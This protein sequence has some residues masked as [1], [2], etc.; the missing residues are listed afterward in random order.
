[1]TDLEKKLQEAA[2][3]YYTDGTS[4][5]TDEEFDALVDQLRIEQPDS[6]LFKVGWG[7]DVADDHTPGMKRKH[8][9]TTIGS[10]DKC[11]D[12]KEIGRDFVGPDLDISTKL[13]GLSCVLYYDHGLLKYALTRGDSFTGIDITDKVL[14]IQPKFAKTTDPF[15]GAIRGEIL[16]S[17]EN[18]EKFKAAHEDA[19]NPRNSTAGLINGKDT[20]E[21]LPY[22][23]IVLYTVVH[24]DEAIEDPMFTVSETREYILRLFGNDDSLV[25]PY[26]TINLDNDDNYI[27]N[28][29]FIK[30]MEHYR[31]DLY[32]QYPA[33][34]LVLS[35]NNIKCDDKGTYI[36]TAK[37]FKFPAESKITKIIDIEWNMSKTKMAVPRV[38]LEPVELSGTTVQACAGYNAQ[39]ILDHKLRPGTLIKIRRSG[40]VIPQIVDIFNEDAGEWESCMDTST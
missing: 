10:L 23:N 24:D 33:D 30:T 14:K 19:K 6:I 28:S 4:D 31:E 40:E 27:D 17:F 29:W 35:K 13:D 15:T 32:R 34:G 26:H 11:H 5:L 18:F 2:Q 38:L 36:Y 20:F 3:K 1:M 16:M 8:L 37:A 12:L 9:Y 21:D 7:Y 39:Y 25:V 22:L